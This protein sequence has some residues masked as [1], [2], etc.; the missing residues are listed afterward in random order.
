MTDND[1]R[2]A[3]LAEALPPDFGPFWDELPQ[4][5]PF[6]HETEFNRE[7]FAAAI[8]AALPPD[9][10]GHDNIQAEFEAEARRANLLTLQL[11]DAEAN[12]QRT[13]KSLTQADAEI[14]RLR[15]IKETARDI[16]SLRHG[17]TYHDVGSII[18]ALRA[19]LEA[20]HA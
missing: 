16:V 13:V 14:A 7:K 11:N 6:V 10:C 12:W 8:L 20:D 18:D 1:P 15:K 3:A 4:P 9:W 5:A 2:I 17:S 19:A